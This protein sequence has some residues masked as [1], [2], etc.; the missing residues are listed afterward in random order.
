MQD[1]HA[2]DA[3]LR[4]AD[5]YKLPR[6]REGLEPLA[7]GLARDLVQLEAELQQLFAD[8]SSRVALAARH[9]VTSGGKRVR[10]TVCL[11]AAR[12]FPPSKPPATLLGLSMVAEAIHSAT[13]LHDDVLDLGESRRGRPASRVLYGNCASVLGGDLLLIEGLK[14]VNA[15]GVPELMTS[16]IDV[17]GRMVR[18]EAQ[19]LE[20]RGRADLSL[21]EYFQ[22]VDGKTASLFEWAMEA[23]ARSVGANDS[24][25][26]AAQSYGK[27]VGYAFQLLD[28]LLDLTR[29]PELIGKG[30]MQDISGGTLTYPV[31]LALQG[32]PELAKRLAEA[33]TSEADDALVA[34]LLE[35]VQ[36]SGA[37][38]RARSLIA[39]HTALAL[40]TLAG[41]PPSPAGDAL[42]AVATAL[43]ERSL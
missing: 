12:S 19:Q 28:D 30:V 1:A 15:A 25:V 40:A 21:D 5:S 33:S 37:A 35:A 41:L 26:E 24:Q 22:V 29:E 31:I 4:L 32:R 14:L 11:L 39:E 7:D 6:I 9:L 3:L 13:L 27:H 36:T 10:P 42:A 8:E 38:D 34:E 16:L 18:A 23:G 20:N 17:L 43:E 2:R